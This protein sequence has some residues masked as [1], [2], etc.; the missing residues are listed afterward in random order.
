MLYCNEDCLKSHH[1]PLGNT[2]DILSWLV[3][4]H[5][6]KDVEVGFMISAEDVLTPLK[7][8]VFASV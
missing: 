6:W 1:Q 8:L 2:S 7:K 3:Y 4:C 5:T